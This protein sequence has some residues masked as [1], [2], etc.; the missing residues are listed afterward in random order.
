MKYLILLLFTFISLGLSA[1]EPK[2][3][4]AFIIAGAVLTKLSDK[5][6]VILSEGLYVK[7][8]EINPKRRDQFIVYD[9]SGV[10]KYQVGALDLVEVAE[11]YKILPVYEAKK[12]YP[13]KSDFKTENKFAKFDSQFNF[14]VD[15]LAL[16]SL[17][18]IYNDQISSVISPRYEI[19]TLYVTELPLEM[20]FNLNY[21]STYWKNDI[22]EVKLSILSL[23]PQFKYK[24]NEIKNFKLAALLGA[25]IAPIYQGSAGAL[26]DKYSAILYDLGV[27]SEWHYPFGI[28]TLGSH[29]RLHRLALSETNRTDSEFLPK[30]YTVSSFGIMFGYKIEWEL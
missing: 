30:E 19:R 24:F 20:G 10:A 23:G 18:N 17:N 28:F 12:V 5:S 6:Q 2:P 29:Y 27:E 16:A 1:E 13:P 4:T 8:L 11:D 14:H 3:Y 15:S 26:K 21:Q 22:E 7:V 9:K 25:E